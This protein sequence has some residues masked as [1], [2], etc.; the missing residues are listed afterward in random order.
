MFETE[1][2][3]GPRAI[4]AYSRLSYTMWYALA[5]FID[6]STQSRENYEGIIDAVLEKEGSPLVVE[7]TY[8]RIGDKTIRVEDNSIGMTRD[9]LVAALKIANPTKDSRGRSKYGMGMKT[10]ACWIGRKWQ[11]VTCEWGS[12]E[13]WTATVDVNAIVNDGAKIP[14]S[15]QSV[16]RDCHY[17][18]IIISDLNRVIQK[19]TE[20]TIRAYLG[21]MYCFDLRD[22]RVKLVYN[23]E[24]IRPPD[25]LEMDTDPDGRQM[26][27]DF[28]TQ[29]DGKMVKGWFGVLRRG[30]RK[31]GGF[32]I[33]RDRRQIQGFPH[34]WKPRSI[35]GGV[36]DEGANNLV[37]QRLTGVIE[38][39]GFEVSHTKDAILF[40]GDEEDQLERYLVAATKDYREYAQRRRGSRGQPW[41]KDK[42]RDLLDSMRKEFTS[43]ELKD[44]ITGSI[45]PPIEVIQA[46]N[47]QQVASLTDSDEVAEI[48]IVPGLR[49]R[50][51]VQER[52]EN[53][54]HLTIVAG[55]EQGTIHV[56]INGLHPYYC[57]LDSV[58]AIDECMRQ[59]L[60]DAV[61]EYQVS[62]QTAR[63]N[64]DSVRRLKDQFLRAKIIQLENAASAVTES[65]ATALGGESGGGIA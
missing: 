11:V 2:T 60:Y 18:R 62:R 7:V 33:F 34:A 56:I 16:D 46:N 52:S 50:F 5:E 53:D 36:E 39:D 25:E 59:Y 30:G 21:S 48:E 63:V 28:E 15:L 42:V 14:L 41:S 22:G 54:P 1:L 31:F 6:N 20:E 64:P 13:E 61:A 57:S 9:D 17:T 37:A 43:D 55:A 65:E 29:I 12:G 4:D 38:L 8:S 26:R 19:R 51:S 49:V 47:Q 44:A 40:A 45:L 27:R 10:A 35:F 24:E 23:N 3:L 58:D 32:S